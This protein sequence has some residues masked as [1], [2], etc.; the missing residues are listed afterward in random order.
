M[1]AMNWS[2]IDSVA[3]GGA[4]L[5]AGGYVVR[6]T[7]VEDVP[8]REY[9]WVEYDVAEGPHKGHYSDDFARAHPYVHRFSRSYKQAA[10]GFFKAFLVALEESNP[11][12]SIGDWERRS[13]E[14]EL[15]G[16]L[17]GVV[18][19][20]ELYTNRDGAD[21][22]RLEVVSIVSADAVRKGAYELPPV[23]DRREGGAGAPA[24]APAASSFSDIP[25]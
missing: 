22:E 14:R 24:K 15:V 20:T 2:I 10:Q 19:Q 1:K 8:G 4:K 5:P 23:R 16:L 18:V 25:F 9:V 6:I 17:V 3:G 7:N 21:K 13:D 12:F 11:Q